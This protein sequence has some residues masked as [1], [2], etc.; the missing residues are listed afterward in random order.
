MIDKLYASSEAAVADIPDGAVIMFG[1]FGDAG[2]AENLTRALAKQGAKGLV[3]VSNAAG[4][5]ERGISM[6]F[7]NNQIRKILASFPVP[8]MSD[9][10]Q[11]R[12]E[13]AETELELVPQGTLVERMRA[14]AAGLGAFYTPTGVGT[15]VAEG[16]EVRAIN[17]RE[18]VLEHPLSA[19]YAL[20]KAY[21]ADRMGNLVY[22]MTARNFNPVMAA[23]ARVTIVEVEEVVE[24]G[25]LDPETIMTPGIFVER[26]VKGEHYEPGWVD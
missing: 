20:L 10:F 8:G 18:Y 4:Q 23:A 7:R 2:V 17:G 9:A 14:A 15:T 3:A 1:G 16:K 11:E 5:R 13:A 26:I 21:K 25:E 24:A 22:R 12:L 19:D 6:L